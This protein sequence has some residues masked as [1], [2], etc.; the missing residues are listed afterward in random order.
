MLFIFIK[1]HF[2][3][4]LCSVDSKDLI[5]IFQETDHEEIEPRQDHG[6]NTSKQGTSGRA[7]KKYCPT[8]TTDS[9]NDRSAYIFYVYCLSDLF[10]VALI[11]HLLPHRPL[12]RRLMA[13]NVRSPLGTQMKTTVSSP[14]IYFYRLFIFLASNLC[15]V[16]HGIVQKSP[17][18]MRL[19][20]PQRLDSLYLI[21]WCRFQ[22]SFLIFC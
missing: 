15:V 8:T 22:Q 16:L 13:R 3:L 9:E 10:F 2:H 12:S 20:C 11:L 14:G 18:L 19:P 6:K 5:D 21:K 7:V 17:V 4:I 1:T